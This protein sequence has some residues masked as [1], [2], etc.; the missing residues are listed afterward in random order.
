MIKIIMKCDIY[1]RLATKLV[2][3]VVFD[4]EYYLKTLAKKFKFSKN[5][6]R[7]S[8]KSCQKTTLVILVI[9]L[10]TAYVGMQKLDL[11]KLSLESFCTFHL[12]L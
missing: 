10:I 6:S 3:N 4:K 12:Y 9:L 8:I 11:N 5:T 7:L 1:P 2:L